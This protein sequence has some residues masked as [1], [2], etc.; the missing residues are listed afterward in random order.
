MQKVVVTKNFLQNATTKYLVTP[1]GENPVSAGVGTDNLELFNMK[2][3]SP[4]LIPY[5]HK[6][7][8]FGCCHVMIGEAVMP[9]AQKVKKLPMKIE[10]DK[11]RQ[12]F[13]DQDGDVV[14]G[15]AQV[16]FTKDN[17]SIVK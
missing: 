11:E 10:Y 14:V 4:F 12:R 7:V 17:I 2:T 13:F 8:A 3:E 16:T 15:A 5:G 1:Y 9:V 6:Y